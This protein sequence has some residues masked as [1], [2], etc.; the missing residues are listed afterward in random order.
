MLQGL[1][2]LIFGII[3]LFGG[4]QSQVKRSEYIADGTRLGFARAMTVILYMGGVSQIIMAAVFLFP[5]K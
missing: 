5:C 1:M 2:H 4:R 3:L